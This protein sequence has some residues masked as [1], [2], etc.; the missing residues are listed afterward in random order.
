MKLARIL[1]PTG[2]VWA[3][4]HESTYTR[5]DWREGRPVDTQDPIAPGRL[6]A[7]VTPP[8]IIAVGLNYRHHAE[9]TGAKIPERPIL[10]PKTLNTLIGPEELIQIPTHLKSEKVDYECELAFVFSKTAKNVSRENAMDYVLGFTVANDISARDWQKDYGG[11]Q[12]MKGKCFDTFC[13]AGPFL[14]TLDDLPNY[15]NTRI[16]TRVNGETL[17]DWNTNDMI[18]DVPSLVEFITG[19]TTVQ[20][21]TMVITGTPQGVGMAR[22]PP[23][24]LQSGDIVE[25]EIEG[26]G[27]LR[28]TVIMEPD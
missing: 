15:N 28:N 24:W 5:V 18:F 2:P 17:Q 16:A 11:G 7:P 1:S 9:E 23:R 3:A 22:T 19:S 10:F 26:I 21:G 6:L 25:A 27:V 20:E 13:P 4:F 12:W 14:V 8:A